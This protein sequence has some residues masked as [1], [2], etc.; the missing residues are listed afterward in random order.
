[1]SICVMG[2]VEVRVLTVR[3]QPIT[4]CLERNRAEGKSRYLVRWSQAVI[5]QV[6]VV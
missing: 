1:M 6:R 3:T 2:R 5:G 4:A